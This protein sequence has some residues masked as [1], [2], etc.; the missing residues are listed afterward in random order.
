M[1]GDRQQLRAERATVIR[2]QRRRRA[3]AGSRPD[4]GSPPGT[5]L[6]PEIRH[7]IVLM[8][9]NHSYDNYL[10]MLPTG[11]GFVLGADGKPDVSNPDKDGHPV[12]ATARGN[13]CQEKGLPTQ[14]WHGSH[15]QWNA[16][17]NDGFIRS[18]E[19]LLKELRSPLPDARVGMSYWIR[20][21]IP[22]YHGLASTFP[23]MDR[24][25]SSCMGPTFPNRR[26]LIAGTAHGLIDNIPTGLFDY[27]EAGTIFDLL[28]ANGIDW[29][30]YHHSTPL[31]LAR[32]RAVRVLGKP[33]LEAIRALGL[34]AA[35]LPGLRGYL[36]G[37]GGL[38]AFL[39][40]KI[41]FTANLYPLGWRGA[42]NHLRPLEAFFRD[43]ADGTLPP[44]SI[45]DPDFTEFSEENPQDI[46]HGEAF[47]ASVI[48]AVMKGK[49]WPHTLLIWTYDEHGGYY[50]H[51]RPPPAVPPDEIV[52]R[53]L[54]EALGK[55]D[56][57]L[58]RFRLWRKLKEANDAR[59]GDKLPPRAYDRL[60]FRVPAVIVS[61]FAKKGYVSS[62]DGPRDGP[63]DG[64][65]PRVYDHT[66]ILKLIECKW[67]LPALTLRDAEAHDFLDALDLE[68]P[69]FLSPPP[70]PDPRRWSTSES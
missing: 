16:G 30:N 43:A 23:L 9:E 20:D 49:G 7:I 70:L 27:P 12:R 26:F 22:F 1:P 53:S 6:L 58:R 40:G 47:A 18:S 33:G 55:L 57:L 25:F 17:K 31:T 32:D 28:T 59:I 35:Q 15:V 41:Q 8:M 64:R 48:K 44:V 50:D 42:R 69:P 52:G 67:N 62:K 45:V 51:V 5:D 36:A 3:P 29:V 38:G 34:F 13:T 10:G 60:G 54:V 37:R 66:S 11:D 61:P 19:G 39:M 63:P 65:G 56:W 14:S 2:A 68:N 4:P 46:S 24:W 21:D